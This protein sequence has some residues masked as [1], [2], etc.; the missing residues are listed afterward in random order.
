[1]ANTAKS[2][3]DKGRTQLGYREGKDNYTKYPPQVPG[4]AW[5]QNQPWCQT[6]ISWLAVQTGNT[7]VIPLT[8]SCLTCTDYYKQRGRF[9]RSNPK[10]G[11]LVMYG[12]SGGTHVDMVTEVSGNRIRVIGGNTG[13][14][15]NGQ[16]FNGDGVY[17]KWTELSNPRIHGFA[18]PAY[19]PGATDETTVLPDVGGD[20]KPPKGKFTVKRGMT[21]LGICALLG[22]SLAELL[23]ANPDIKDPDKIGEGQEINIPAER[24][25]AKPDPVKPSPSKSAE[26][27]KQDE[28]KPEASKK[29]AP[30]AGGTGKPVV[31]AKPDKEQPKPPVKP[32]PDTATTYRVQRGD[33]LSAIALKHRV[34]LSALLAANA[35]RFNNP[36]LIFL[37]Q[38]VYLPAPGSTNHKDSVHKPGCPCTCDHTVQGKPSKPVAPAP[39]PPSTNSGISI[40]SLLPLRTQGVQK[41]WDRPLNAAEIENARIIRVEAL[42]AFGPGARRG[43]RAA[44]VGIA[45]AYQESRL[46]NLQGGDSD[47]AGLFQQRPSMG[48]GTHTQVTDPHYA[49]AKF[50]STLKAKFGSGEFSYLTSVPLIELS[51]RVQLSGSPSLPGHFELSAARLVVQL[52]GGQGEGGSLDDSIKNASK[53]VVEPAEAGLSAGW[54]KPVQAQKGT[55]FGQRGSMWSSGA[56]TGLDFPAPHGTTVVAAKAGR[57]E[58]AGWAGAYGR[59]VVIDHGGGIKTRYAHLSAISV[60]VGQEIAG[61]SPI[62]NVGTTGNSTGPHLHLEV[63]VNG[64]Q[65]DP[66]RFIG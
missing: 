52:G 42:R 35:G 64:V 54:V 20:K 19:K 49:A 65:V 32:G 6:W 2:M 8:A 55:P 29:P 22:V 12:A 1:M 38:T 31:P 61:G 50:F 21:L 16:Y 45:T 25:T 17:E 51:H 56:H 3:I 5:A 58:F 10:P 44:V 46:Q 59:S 41:S 62:G 60:G 43:E 23:T 34:S 47:S 53:A 37:G 18:R 57:V 4:L 11:D 36:D 48:W 63:I 7:D 33:T 26:K 15:Y 40:E 14:S 30:D 13:G 66:A 27:G 24:E 39:Q 9:H 28:S